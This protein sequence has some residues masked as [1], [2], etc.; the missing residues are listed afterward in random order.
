MV[1]IL[2]FKKGETI[3]KIIAVITNL[4]AQG[5]LMSYCGRNKNMKNIPLNLLTIEEGGNFE[6]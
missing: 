1:E 2:H 3:I 5:I 6:E 4:D